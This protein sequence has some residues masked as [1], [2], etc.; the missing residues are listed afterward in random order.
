MMKHLKLLEVIDT[1]D[2]H[3]M[4]DKAVKKIS[5]E[6][7]TGRAEGGYWVLN[8]LGDDYPQNLSFARRVIIRASNKNQG[9]NEV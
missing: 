3:P 4:F 6:I 1:W 8:F 2:K 9:E 5:K 7:L